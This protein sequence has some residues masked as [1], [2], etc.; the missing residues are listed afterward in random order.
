MCQGRQFARTATL[1]FDYFIFFFIHA[2]CECCIQNRQSR[3]H[4]V[5]HEQYYSLLLLNVRPERKSHLREREG[6]LVSKLVN[7]G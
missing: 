7:Q 3:V 4:N 1:A 6:E 2:N 5:A